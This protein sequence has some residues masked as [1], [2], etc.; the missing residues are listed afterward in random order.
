MYSLPQNPVFLLLFERQGFYYWLSVT[1]KFLPKA[2]NK[3]M[4]G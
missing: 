4:I 2:A 3:M 1:K